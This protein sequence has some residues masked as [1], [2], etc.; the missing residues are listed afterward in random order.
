[1]SSRRQC[2]CRHGNRQALAWERARQWWGRLIGRLGGGCKEDWGAGARNEG[3]EAPP[4]GRGQPEPPSSLGWVQGAL[5]S[6]S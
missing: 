2:R 5:F 1:M 3:P 6:S 4:P